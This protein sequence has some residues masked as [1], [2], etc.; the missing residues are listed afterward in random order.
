MHSP[1]AGVGGSLTALAT[2]FRNMRVDCDALSGFPERQIIRD[3]AALIVCGSTGE[4]ATLTQ[5]EYASAVH[6]VVETA[7]GH[8]PGTG[9]TRT[10]CSFA[11]IGCNTVSGAPSIR[12]VPYQHPPCGTIGMLMPPHVIVRL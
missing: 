4:A 6:T 2:P 12:T 10:R 5:P 1:I 7:A 3:T 11:S 8:G 9:G